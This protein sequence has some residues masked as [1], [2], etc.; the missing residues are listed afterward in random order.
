MIDTVSFPK[1]NAEGKVKIELF[2]DLTGRKVEEVKTNNFIAKGVEYYFKILMMNQFTRDKATGA[3]NHTVDSLFEQMTLTDASHAEQPEKEWYMKGNVI[4]WALTSGTYIGDD[5][6]R[7]SYNTAE[8]FTKQK[9]VHIVVDFPTHAANGTFQSIYFTPSGDPRNYGIFRPFM[10]E[11]L[12][13]V[14]KV[15]KYNN[16]IW[17]LHSSISYSYSEGHYSSNSISRYDDNFNHIKTYNLPYD[18]TDVSP[19]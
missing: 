11:G 3:I 8:S 7:G 18:K 12:P 5:N 1:L 16:E 10:L 13:G 14:L 17:V 15:Q 19:K 9:Q 6:K 4:G 2:D